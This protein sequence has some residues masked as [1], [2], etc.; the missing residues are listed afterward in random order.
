MID[1]T[2]GAPIDKYF[3]APNTRRMTPDLLIAYFGGITATAKALGVKPPSV[4]EWKSNGVVPEGRQY[5]VEVLT[6][7]EL[8]AARSTE[9][10]A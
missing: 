4:S 6:G 8:K 5:Q 9:K 3:G 10:A 1:E 7:G 2:F